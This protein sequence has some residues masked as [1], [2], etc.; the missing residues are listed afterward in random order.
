VREYAPVV[1]AESLAGL[2]SLQSHQLEVHGLHG[3]QLRVS[4]VHAVEAAFRAIRESPF[5][6]VVARQVPREL[7]DGPLSRDFPD[8]QDAL[9]KATHCC[10]LCQIEGLVIIYFNT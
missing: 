8:V 3:P 7:C 10:H 9:R 5:E 6:V 2:Q 1:T 4:E